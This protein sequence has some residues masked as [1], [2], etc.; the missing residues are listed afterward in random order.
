MRHVIV[1]YTVKPE[2]L[3]THEAL[4]AGV[5][6]QLAEVAPAGLD[7]QVVRLADGRSFVH[8]ARVEGAENPLPALSAF[9]AFS[10]D[11]KSRC[12]Q[13]PS[14][15]EGTCVGSYGRAPGR[16]GILGP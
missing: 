6:A 16:E 2:C 8:M 11:I 1:R 4:L 15:A 12:E 10:A 9:R 3:D 13:P 14:S 5:F 7:Y